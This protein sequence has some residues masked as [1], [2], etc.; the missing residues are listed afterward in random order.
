VNFLPSL[1]ADIQLAAAQLGWVGKTVMVIG[2][3]KL[4]AN[5]TSGSA[6]WPPTRAVFFFFEPVSLK[7]QS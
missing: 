2:A 3:N 5:Y 1:R 6:D 7:L 4:V